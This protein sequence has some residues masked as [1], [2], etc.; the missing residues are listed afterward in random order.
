MLLNCNALSVSRMKTA[1]ED[2][3]KHTKLLNEMKKDLDYIFKKIRA[4]QLK[5]STQYPD[6]FAEAQPQRGSF[7]EEAEDEYEKNQTEEQIQCSSTAATTNNK[8][9]ETKSA[10]KIANDNKTSVAYVKM[11]Q[12]PE[13]GVSVSGQWNNEVDKRKSIGSN[14]SLST[15]N[16]NDSSE[17]T[18]GVESS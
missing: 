6:A 12:S 1:G 9:T 16:S 11:K 14:N 13:N 10:K 7:A 5:V 4:I 17:P 8:A 15:D 18:S 3:K 2:F